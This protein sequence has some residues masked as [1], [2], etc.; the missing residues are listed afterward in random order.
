MM[1]V[2]VLFVVIVGVVGAAFGDVG[3]AVAVALGGV[4]FLVVGVVVAVREA[5]TKR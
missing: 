4:V 1:I 2:V 3:K 5:R